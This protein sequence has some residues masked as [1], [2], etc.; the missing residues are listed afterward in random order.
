[1]W[2]HTIANAAAIRGTSASKQKASGRTR[3][4]LAIQLHIYNTRTWMELE[5][6][7]QG[8]LY[9]RVRRWW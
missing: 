3:S 4:D 7:E 1:M 8:I 9:N 6:T 5:E 2:C